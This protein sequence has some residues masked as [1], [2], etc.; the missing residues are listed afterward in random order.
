LLCLRDPINEELG[1]PD[2]DDTPV[3]DRSDKR[4]DTPVP[5]VRVYVAHRS[6]VEEID[7]FDDQ[8]SEHGPSAFRRPGL[9]YERVEVD[10]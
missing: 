7:K 4:V 9:L 5:W 6:T 2:E 1:L 3:I 8:P 10:D